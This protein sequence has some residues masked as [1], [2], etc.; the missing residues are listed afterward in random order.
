M[1][2]LSKHIQQQALR[3]K[4]GPQRLTLHT[5]VKPLR[6]SEL[7]SREDFHRCRFTVSKKHSAIGV[8]HTLRGDSAL[9]TVGQGRR[10]TEWLGLNYVLSTETNPGGLTRKA[11]PYDGLVLFLTRSCFQGLEPQGRKSQEPATPDTRTRPMP[12]SLGLD[13]GLSFEGNPGGL[14]GQASPCAR[15]VLSLPRD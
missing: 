3:A 7:G 6:S 14:T 15:L 12:G 2:L 11:S 8:G 1:L 9:W 10:Q 4:A 13:Y 5:S